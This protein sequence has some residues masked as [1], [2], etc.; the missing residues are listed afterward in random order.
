MAQEFDKQ[1]ILV[2]GGGY[3]GALAAVRLAGRARDRAAVTLVDPR[4][5]LVQRLRLHQLATGQR[6]RA[7]DLLRL[8]G[9]RVTNVRGKAVAIDP[10]RGRAAVER[11]GAISEIPFDQVLIAVGSG[12]DVDSVPGVRE[13]AHALSG[14][15][16]AERLWAELRGAG[17][18]S[19][20]VVC[21]GGFTGIEA[22]SEI[23]VR[24]PDLRVSLLSASRLGA[25][26]SERGREQLETRLAKKGVE[27]IE[28]ERVSA[29][30]PGRVSLVGGTE[31]E[32]DLVV[33]CAGFAAHPLVRDSGLPV[34]SRGLLALDGSLRSVRHA[35]VLG[36][37][38]VAAIPDFPN[39]AHY[40]M[41]C[42]A[43]MPSGAHAADTALAAMK[44]ETPRPF[45]FG[46]IHI[47]LSLGRGDGLIQFVDRADRPK[48]KV[49]AGRS[50][51]I[52]KEIVTRSP[53]P[54]IAWERRLP[55]MLRWPSGGAAPAAQ[56]A[57][58]G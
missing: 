32:A 48:R 25:V 15:A 13:H 54:S 11:D 24:R 50:A 21:G 45:D 4:T 49:L 7:Y 34:D 29:V 57:T 39:G 19:R 17:E 33:W 40:R 5:E 23:A 9:R 46:Y 18:G 30:E 52:Y 14:P 43:G 6:V 38:D 2:I 28:G 55:G 56:A 35:N 42:Q 41:T 36:A 53:V 12:I 20:V 31:M 8:T 27:V 16:A 58:P 44:G 47:P 37:G 3:A 22:A 1:R 10:D 26:F 51:A